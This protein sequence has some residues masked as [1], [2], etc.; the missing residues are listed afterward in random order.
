MRNIISPA[1][2]TLKQREKDIN[3]EFEEK[4]FQVYQAITA[5]YHEMFFDLYK[6]RVYDVDVSAPKTEMER[7]AYWVVHRKEYSKPDVFHDIKPG[8]TVFGKCSV[9]YG[10]TDSV[11]VA[12]EPLDWVVDKIKESSHC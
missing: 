10:D 3:K 6:V 4:I 12:F 7:D 8:E 11:M 2:L 5:E 1:L 9:V